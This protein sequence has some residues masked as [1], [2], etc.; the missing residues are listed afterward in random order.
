MSD[1]KSFAASLSQGCG[2]WFV[3]LILLIA[4]LAIILSPEQSK[5]PESTPI[6]PLTLPT[7]TFLPGTPSPVPPI[8]TPIPPPGTP[9]SDCEPGI[10]VG[11]TISVIHHAVRMR[12]SPGYVE[13]D[14]KTDTKHYM[15]TGDRVVVKGGPE[16]TDRLCW[17]FI[18]HEG[19]QGWTADHSHQGRLLLSVGP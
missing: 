7:A 3:V 17:W 19:W 1:R 12:H 11:K 8:D 10:A 13:K 14:D 9:S 4:L 2:V 6:S 18:E 15:E 5:P 16:I